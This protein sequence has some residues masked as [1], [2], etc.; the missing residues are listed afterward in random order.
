M[1]Q[2]LP[3][4]ASFFVGLQVASL[5]WLLVHAVSVILAALVIEKKRFPWDDVFQY[6]SLA[7]TNLR[8]GFLVALNTA[9][10]YVT[11]LVS[12]LASNWQYVALGALCLSAG[13]VLAN[14]QTTVVVAVDDVWQNVWATVL[15]PSRSVLNLLFIFLEALVGVINF[16]S[17]YVG[18]VF[19]DTSKVLVSAPG[20]FPS[21]F[22]G[23][24]QVAQSVSKFVTGAV[25]WVI[26]VGAVQRGYTY[27]VSIPTDSSSTTGLTDD[28][29]YSLPDDMGSYAL[30]RGPELDLQ[31]VVKPLR[32][33]FYDA[34]LRVQH[35]CPAE[36]GILNV[37]VD[38]ILDASP[39][40]TFVDSLVSS[41]FNSIVAL[42]EAFLI[43]AVVYFKHQRFVVPNVNPFFD[44]VGRVVGNSEAIANQLILNVF[45]FIEEKVGQPVAWTPPQ[46]FSVLARFLDVQIRVARFFANAVV[47]AP[48]ILNFEAPPVKPAVKLY[49]VFD[50][51]PIYFDIEQV[52]NI[53]GVVIGQIYPKYLNGTG[54]V[55]RDVL[56]VFVGYG[57]F[58]TFAAQRLLLGP[59][60]HNATRFSDSYKNYPA[61]SLAPVSGG[62]APWV[63]FWTGLYDV[64]EKFDLSVTQRIYNLAYTLQKNFRQYFPPLATTVNL[65]MFSLANLQSTVL[66]Q[67]VYLTTAVLTGQAPYYQC[68]LDLANV[69]RVTVDNFIDTLPDVV[70][71]FINIPF[72][73]SLSNAHFNCQLSNV[74]NFIL[75]GSLKSF[76]FAGKMCNAHYTD[77]SLVA[78]DFAHA[79]DCPEYALPY[80]D[81]NPNILCAVDTTL[82]SALKTHVQ[83]RRILLQYAEKQIVQA[84][85]CIISPSDA[86]RCN[87]GSFVSIHAQL[88]SA[89]VVGCYTYEMTIKIANVVAAMLS[90][91][92]DVL[93]KMVVSDG[94]PAYNNLVMSKSDLHAFALGRHSTTGS[95]QVQ[96]VKDHSSGAYEHICSSLYSTFGC[97]AN[98]NCFWDGVA[99][100]MDTGAHLEFQQFP[101]EAATSTFFVAVFAPIFW[102]QY[103]LFLQASR[104]GT[105][106]DTSHGGFVPLVQN[107]FVLF[108]EDPYFIVLD[109]IR[110][111][112]LAVRDMVYG[113]IELIRTFLYVVN[114]CTSVCTAQSVLDF[115][116]FMKAL[117]EIVEFLEEIVKFLV[118]TA[119]KMVVDIGFIFNDVLSMFTGGD[120]DDKFKDILKRFLNI[121]DNFVSQLGTFFM[122]I[123]GAKDICGTINLVIG[124]VL[125]PLI[126]VINTI[127]HHNID[128]GVASFQLGTFFGGI[129]T[130][131]DVPR[132]KCTFADV[133]K[134]RPEAT[135]CSLNADC[136]RSD[137]QC[138]IFRP[139]MCL[140]PTYSSSPEYDEW[141]Y[142]CPCS[143]LSTGNFFCNYASGFCEEGLSPFADPLADCPPA[144]ALRNPLNNKSAF[145]DSTDYFN[146]MCFVVPAYECKDWPNA[147]ATTIYDCMQRRFLN[148]T[149]PNVQGPYLCR[150]FCSPSSLNN[151]NLLLSDPTVGCFCALGMSIGSNIEP[152]DI[153]KDFL[154]DNLALFDLPVASP[155]RPPRPPKPPRPPPPPNQDYLV[156]TP[157][158]GWVPLAEDGACGSF[159]DTFELMVGGEGFYSLLTPALEVLEP[160]LALL[161]VNNFQSLIFNDFLSYLDGL[162]PTTITTSERL[163]TAYMKSLTSANG[164]SQ[165]LKTILQ[166]IESI[167][168]NGFLNDDT[169]PR[170]CSQTFDFSAYRTVYAGLQ[171][172]NASSTSSVR[173]VDLVYMINLANKKSYGSDF[174]NLLPHSRTSLGVTTL[175]FNASTPGQCVDRVTSIMANSY[176]TLETQNDFQYTL[177]YSKLYGCQVCA[178]NA[179]FKPK[180][181]YV[182]YVRQNQIKQNAN[183]CFG[184]ASCSNASVLPPAGYELTGINVYCDPSTNAAWKFGVTPTTCA[185]FANNGS[186]S[187]NWNDNKC[188]VCPTSGVTSRTFKPQWV[189]YSLIKPSPPLPSPPPR[190][191]MPSP[192]NPPPLPKPPAPPSPPVRVYFHFPPPPSPPLES[193]PTPPTPPTPPPF[194]PFPPLSP[195]SPLRSPKPPSPSPYPK[196]PPVPPTPPPHPSRPPQPPKPPSPPPL[197][198]S[199]SPPPPPRP[200]AS[201]RRLLATGCSS[202]TACSSWDAACTHEGSALLCASCPEQNF[203]TQRNAAA[204]VRGAC[205]CLV[206]ADPDAS[207]MTWEGSS[208]CAVIG[209]A[210]SNASVLSA[211]ERV[212]VRDCARRYASFAAAPRFAYDYAEALRVGTHY[213]LGALLGLVAANQSDDNLQRVFSE[214]KVDPVPAFQAAHKVRS[215]ARIARAVHPDVAGHVESLMSRSKK[216][217]NAQRLRGSFAFLRTATSNVVSHILA[218]KPAVRAELSALVEKVEVRMEVAQAQRRRLHSAQFNV[219][220]PL[221]T[222]FV[223]DLASASTNLKNHMNYN[224][225]RQVC[226]FINSNWTVCP[227]ASWQ[228]GRLAPTA[229]VKNST[230]PSLQVTPR[231]TS[232][233]GLFRLAKAVT[234]YDFEA[235]LQR[236]VSNVARRLP[237][238]PGFGTAASKATDKLKCGYDTAL[239]CLEKP[240]TLHNQVMRYILEAVVVSTTLKVLSLGSLNMVVM[241]LFFLL[242]YPVIM[243]RAYGLQYGCSITPSPVVPVCLTSEVQDLL[244]SLT[245]RVL[246]WPSPLVNS[247]ARVIHKVSGNSFTSYNTSELRPSD[248]FD[249]TT[250]GFGDG[251]REL[252]YLA[253]RYVPGWQGVFPTVTRSRIFGHSIQEAVDSFHVSSKHSHINDQC[254]SLFSFTAIP[255]ILLVAL[256]AVFAAAALHITLILF[257]YTLAATKNMY[258]AVIAAYITINNEDPA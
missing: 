238:R 168:S 215:F 147:S 157:I 144:N 158:A 22:D 67:S 83:T 253:N 49:D 150:D 58:A 255:V 130:I 15:K 21:F 174:V 60:P 207:T 108:T 51:V 103:L 40:S 24:P 199:P 69:T 121:I 152:L 131:P 120:P 35:A 185:P 94:G 124:E 95:S 6:L 190:P 61:C 202:D 195:P 18:T 162:V 141:D 122:N 208:R 180:R 85:A 226:R 75:A 217:P 145:V 101:L 109:S 87:S 4:P 11:T 48:V 32:L 201:A 214:L 41:A 176:K 250:L 252:V 159:F 3:T 71:F 64:M 235:A 44:N 56:D 220:C 38:G 45:K 163:F 161:K 30:V 89:S 200:K 148:Q 219:Q 183:T 224:V 179:V 115:K 10:S 193:P 173:C 28:F 254:A 39:T 70:E 182:T 88:A 246:P 42:P 165:S 169:F 203:W 164:V 26:A 218:S 104:L 117:T 196:P 107:L 65:G 251:V 197:P 73:Q 14:Y 184:L 137:A 188:I 68:M 46:F 102:Q 245:P 63:Q 248:V 231:K 31:P 91:A 249:C 5:F 13:F 142:A 210:Y 216:L 236:L 155:P 29:F 53:T 187:W 17:Q 86:Q 127:F 2:L 100:H 156:A 241:P 96:S 123:P 143:A 116:E 33:V 178:R 170:N 223:T 77:G 57:K 230:F 92:Y 74:H 258:L 198:P 114:K 237:S 99:C 47:H 206:P 135:V 177:T 90:P 205:A 146:S 211:L 43:S 20:Y 160:T 9:A 138:V 134:P 106:L 243:N 111:G 55:L 225:P 23:I 140:N 93:Y 242:S 34:V 66:R 37:A 50:F 1:S 25:D 256:A 186:F 232:S 7:Q 84:L 175:N 257:A 112:T 171:T 129:P 228:V 194:P 209:R 118:G 19:K 227:P 72:A 151:D 12:T 82:V 8:T 119:F 221:L 166:Y 59:D 181:G 110:L 97:L 233:D 36:N 126:N 172:V 247:S 234:G 16:L 76:Y 149:D 244:H 191:P 80:A 136:V 128:I 204:C 154:M 153:A 167:N 192:P 125:N 62:A 212:E 132:L 105:V 213:G 79:Q 113:F 133:I 78:C 54:L 239:Q 189:T 229:P 81:I 98:I 139:E 222:N 240:G 52:T 27:T